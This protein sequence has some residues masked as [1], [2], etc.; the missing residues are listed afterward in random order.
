MHAHPPPLSPTT[1]YTHQAHPSQDAGSAGQHTCSAIKPRPV[2][3][4]YEVPGVLHG[5]SA[6]DLGHAG[7]LQHQPG[8][9]SRLPEQV[10]EN[11]DML[12]SDFFWPY[13]CCQPRLHNVKAAL[14]ISG[15]TSNVCFLN[16]KLCFTWYIKSRPRPL[17]YDVCYLCQFRGHTCST[18]LNCVG[19]CTDKLHWHLCSAT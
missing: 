13:C 11:A 4:C 3:V 17:S 10:C 5:H 19:W 7:Q 1:K 6:G 9:L 16:D 8:A 14:L 18:M 12:L 15:C 2:Q